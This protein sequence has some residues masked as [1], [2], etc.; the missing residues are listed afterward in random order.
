VRLDNKNAEAHDDLGVT[1][2]QQGQYAKAELMFKTALLIDPTYQKAFH[3]LAMVQHITGNHAEALKAADLAVALMPD[4]RNSLL[5][6]ATIL[7]TMGRYSESKKLLERANAL[8]EGKW[9]ERMEIQ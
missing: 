5:L 2:A 8:D 7:E 3:N 9:T 4:N 1:Y 6:M